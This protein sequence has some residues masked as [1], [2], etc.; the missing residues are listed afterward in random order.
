MRRFVRGFLVGTAA[1]VTATTVMQWRRGRAAGEVPFDRVRIWGNERLNPWLLKRGLAGGRRSEIGMIEHV[2]R[3]TGAVHL[4]PIHPTFTAD[5]QVWIPV[6]YGEMSQ[7]AQNIIAAGHARLQ[8][9]D[10]LYDLDQPE[11]VAAHEDPALSPLAARA[12]EWLDV[13]YLRLVRVA[14]VP[15]T[16]GTRQPGMETQAGMPVMEPPLDAT[17]PLPTLDLPAEPIAEAEHET[18]EEREPVLV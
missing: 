12:A 7:W 3:K 18:A 8:W 1:A 6:P 9:H 4:T 10:T 5:G 16:F 15:G 2:G 14:E 11:I 17:F 13:R